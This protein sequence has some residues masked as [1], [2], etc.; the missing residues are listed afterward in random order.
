MA[1]QQAS[2]EQCKRRHRHKRPGSRRRLQGP[3]SGANSQRMCLVDLRG[4]HGEHP[5]SLRDVAE[6]MGRPQPAHVGDQ[7]VTNYSTTNVTAVDERSIHNIAVQTINSVAAQFDEA[8]A[9]NNQ[10]QQQMMQSLVEHARSHLQRY[11]HVHVYNLVAPPNEHEDMHAVNSSGPP[12][13][14]GLGLHA[15]GAAARGRLAHTRRLWSRS[16][17][18]IHD[19]LLR[20]SLPRQP[21][22]RRLFLLRWCA[23][24]PTRQ[25][26]NNAPGNLHREFTARQPRSQ[27]LRLRS[28]RALP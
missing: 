11:N 8:T 4:M 19:L 3:P 22:P 7:S 6:R 24:C 16:A 15:R 1:A 28:R 21:K 26:P 14:P 18:R 25:C 10:S 9:R 12:P 20:F 17:R 5:T 27:R 13:P 2:H 23:A